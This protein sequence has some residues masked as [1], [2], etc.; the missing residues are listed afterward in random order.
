MADMTMQE[1]IEQFLTATYGKD[2]RAALVAVAQNMQEAKESQDQLLQTAI[3]SQDQTIQDA[4]DSQLMTISETESADIRITDNEGRVYYTAANSKIGS[5][6]H[7]ETTAKSSLV[8]AINENKNNIDNATVIDGSITTEKLDDEAVTRPKVVDQ[9][10]N[11]AK[12]DFYYHGSV[13]YSAMWFTYYMNGNMIKQG[14]NISD[15]LL[16]EAVSEMPDTFCLLGA[17]TQGT[18][19]P[20][21]C[22]FVLVSSGG[23][24]SYKAV[25]CEYENITVNGT[26]YRYAYFN[27]ADFISAYEQYEAAKADNRYYNG[28]QFYLYPQGNFSTEDIKVLSTIP[29]AEMIEMDFVTTVMSE[30]FVTAVQA[31]MSGGSGGASSYEEELTKARLTGKVMINFGDSYTKNMATFCS[32][33]ATKYG[34]V[35]D[36]QGMNG[37]TIIGN[38]PTM[39]DTMISAY[40]SGRTINGTTYHASDVA[41]ITFMGGANDGAGIDT[42]IGNG[43]HVT[44]TSKIYGACHALFKLLANTFTNAKIIVIA[45]PSNFNQHVSSFTTEAQATALG[46]TSLAEL[47]R[48]DDYQLSEYM[49]YNKEKAIMD[50]AKAYSFPLIDM[51]SDFPSMLNPAN[52]TAYWSSSDRIHINSA[53]SQL[54][55][56][57]LDKKIVEL[58]VG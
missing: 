10:V 56:K 55:V 43:L 28:F 20:P 51:F 37:A 23:V 11:M 5:L 21:V 7:L 38:F 17:R 8:A 27:K 32:A 52:R 49:M 36:D 4:I 57:A 9:A 22:R 26:L 14:I 39:A 35:A 48:L 46:F 58:T 31:A 42:Y 41:F 19:N 47:Q 53:G 2:V 54:I 44:D 40:T 18:V 45:Q 15:A 34:M 16:S 50:I 13:E 33:L 12:T 29:T 6:S 25:P 1:A 3:S 30:D 24:S